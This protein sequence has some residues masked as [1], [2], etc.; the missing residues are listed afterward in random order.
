MLE[1]LQVWT[2]SINARGG[3]N[4]HRVRLIVADDGGDP[5]RSKALVQ[6]AVER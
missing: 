5:A 1:A 2:A 6:D 4:G 3:L